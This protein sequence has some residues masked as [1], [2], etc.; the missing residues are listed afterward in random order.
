MRSIAVEVPF[1]RQMLEVICAA[2][3][4]GTTLLELKKHFGTDSPAKQRSLAALL[5]QMQVS[6]RASAYDDTTLIAATDQ[7][8]GR[9]K[10]LR[11]WSRPAHLALMRSNALFDDETQ[12]KFVEPQALHDFTNATPVQEWTDV[13]ERIAAVRVIQRANLGSV[14]QHR[15]ASEKK[16]KKARVNPIDPVTGVAKRGRPRKTPAEKA[17]TSRGSAEKQ[18]KKDATAAAK[19]AKKEPKKL[20]RPKKVPDPNVPPPEPK[21]KG[22][23]RKPDSELSKAALARRKRQEKADAAAAAAGQAP[24]DEQAEEEEE[25]DSTMAAQAGPSSAGP[26]REAAPV[27]QPAAPAA[28]DVPDEEQAGDAA[29]APPPPA[30]RT[31]RA[32]T[33]EEPQ[34]RSSKRARRS[35]LAPAEEEA[36][37]AAVAN[38]PVPQIAS[39]SGARDVEMPP[40]EA[41]AQPVDGP[42]QSAEAAAST[43]EG[44]PVPSDE[45]SADAELPASAAD[46]P[47]TP[48][49][50]N[51][52]A[53]A[54]KSQSAAPAN[55]AKRRRALLLATFLEQH[56][57]ISAIRAAGVLRNF[58]IERGDDDFTMFD[59]TKTRRST[60]QYLE[61]RGTAKSVTLAIKQEGVDSPQQ[62]VYYHASTSDD[63]LAAYAKEF[64]RKGLGAP[65]QQ[66]ALD[67]DVDEI[68]RPAGMPRRQRQVD[69]FHNVD[70]EDLLRDPQYRKQFDDEVTCSQPQGY[71]SGGMARLKQLHL[72]VMGIFE[73]DNSVA[74]GDE[75]DAA[76]VSHAE[77]VIDVEQLR[78]ASLPVRELLKLVPS[79]PSPQLTAV[80]ESAD[81]KARTAA[82]LG[83]EIEEWARRDSSRKAFDALLRDLQLLDLAQP[84]RMHKDKA[85][86]LPA[87]EQPESKL[88]QFHRSDRRLVGFVKATSAP[89]LLPSPK[90]LSTVIEA[91]RFW[92]LIRGAPEV[93]AENADADADDAD[94]EIVELA[95]RMRKNHAW[96]RN[97]QLSPLQ[98][99][100][101]ARFDA[102]MV[103]E[104]MPEQRLRNIAEVA[105]V[106][107][108]VAVEWYSKKAGMQPLDE[109]HPLFDARSSKRAKTGPDDGSWIKGTGDVQLDS[110]AQ[111]IDAA[112]EAP[113][114]VKGE[115][116]ARRQSEAQAKAAR[117]RAARAMRQAEAKAARERAGG[118]ESPASGLRCCTRLTMCRA[119]ARR[120]L[121]CRLDAC[122]RR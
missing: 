74:D 22:R 71:L 97:Y 34:E 7:G 45:A 64:L 116:A 52:T 112:R 121:E 76:L 106:P 53:K 19:A 86:A 87:G 15:P 30:K 48:A 32:R 77:G 20:G 80:A 78:L 118:S 40:V 57:F 3:T 114:T 122:A 50:R 38:D 62:K 55:F 65:A 110:L 46:A 103:A 60:F 56:K 115:G 41:P 59:D 44:A 9:T 36:A 100:F 93:V 70:N 99:R 119:Q 4:R 23:P 51:G 102:E 13:E 79:E 8:S 111:I 6:G 101:L 47:A 33:K 67:E 96:S 17:S 29:E 49:R 85:V 94:P 82:Q 1:E 83:G 91:R 26:S 11:Y 69:P 35:K 120:S 27:E 5:L 81:E 37:A 24:E 98:T 109:S 104:Q 61:E 28:A 68:D 92:T 88:W 73:A 72:A 10:E 21:K 105:R 2:G 12:A 16:S 31:S 42:S 95:R 90:P 117:K 18:A 89:Q 43:D 39:T 107:L 66:H 14:A 108:H 63:E 54:R 113:V 25:A 58:L 75:I 84:V